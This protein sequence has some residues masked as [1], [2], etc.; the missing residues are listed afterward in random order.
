MV[1]LVCSAFVS[2]FWHRNC[3]KRSPGRGFSGT[4]GNSL[5]AEHKA[6]RHSPEIIYIGAIQVPL[7]HPHPP[8]RLVSSFGSCTLYLLPFTFQLRRLISLIL[9]LVLLKEALRNRR[10]TLFHCS[11]RSLEKYSSFILCCSNM[12][13][14]FKFNISNVLYKFLEL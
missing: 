3:R 1:L 5:P 4:E 13:L 8:D 6:Q 14:I 2:V 7:Y 10:L 12:Y 11:R 9:I